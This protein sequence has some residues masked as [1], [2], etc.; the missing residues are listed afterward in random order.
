LQD[1]LATAD[2]IYW[3]R[4]QEERFKDNPAE[5]EAIKNDF[6]MTPALLRQ[7]KAGAV[8]MHPL[9]R[10]HEMGTRDDHDLLDVDPRAIYFEQ[11]ENGMFVR[12]GLLA[13]VLVD[14][15]V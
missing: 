2:V 12:M 11:M 9:P 8:L 5:Y 7:A 1:V 3:T 10:K 13:K 6:I 15:H 4:V 14:A